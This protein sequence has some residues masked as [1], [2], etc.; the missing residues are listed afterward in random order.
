MAGRHRACRRTTS[1]S[2]TSRRARRSGANSSAAGTF[3]YGASDIQYQQLE[4]PELQTKRCK[5]KSLAAVLRLRAGQRGRARVHVQPAR[6]LG[7]PGHQ[8]QADAPGR[9]QDLHGRDHEVE[10]PGDR[11]DE[12]AIRVVQPAASSRWSAPTAPARATCSPSSAS[13]SPPN[14]WQAFVAQQKGLGTR[15]L[16]PEFLAGQPTSDWPQE[17]WGD[18]PVTVRH[19]GRNRGLRR[20]P[21][22]R[23]E[24]DHVRRRRLR[25]GA[26]FPDGVGAE[27]GGRVY[28][29]R[30]GQRHRRA[31]IRA[32]ARQRN[33]PT[34]VQGPDPRAY[35]PS[36]Y[37][38][39]LAQTAG[40]DAG[41]GATLGQFLCYAV[42][43]GQVDR[44]AAPVRAALERPREHRDRRDRADSRRA[45][46]RRLSGRGR[47][48]AP[49]AA[50]AS[51]CGGIPTTT[52][53][54]GAGP[55]G[56]NGGNP[57]FERLEWF[58][59]AR[60]HGTSECRQER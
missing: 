12:S 5:G 40:F 58:E 15:D 49:A 7:E 27:R 48:A 23:A 34:R 19:R 11:R 57:G 59:L 2:T 14:V 10:R 32:E 13:R 16:T 44:A 6:Q 28:P 56:V 4:M 38:Y 54:A 17:G 51:W 36:T 55:N 60:A 20:R 24:R 31:R 29:T 39:V 21:D 9:V 35:F 50:V 26:Q 22:R 53:V 18:H 3:D 30:R 45:V 42:S 43:Q 46:G 37:S 52:T 33:V 47:P 41:K 1:R 8:P 25:E